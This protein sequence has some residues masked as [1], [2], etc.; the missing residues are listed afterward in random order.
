MSEEKKVITCSACGNEHEEQVK[1]C[2]N[3]GS[4]IEEA[5]VAETVETEPA[6]TAGP[7]VTEPAIAD[8]QAEPAAEADDTAADSA[9]FAL[10]QSL[11]QEEP[12]VTDPVAETEPVQTETIAPEP[13]VMESPEPQ[14]MNPVYVEVPAQNT[15]TYTTIDE[16]STTPAG[17]GSPGFGI[18]SLVLGILSLI[19]CCFWPVSLTC[20]IVAIIL[21]IV[22]VYNKYDGKGMAIAGIVLGA[23]SIVFM[24]LLLVLVGSAGMLEAFSEYS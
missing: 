1:F 17:N 7:E 13:L 20:G 18:A 9:T 8:N 3:C 14:T 4:K 16:G 22:A 23:I 21:G 19:C 12:S 11:L 15:N 6:E 10:E 24:I 5:V 2:S